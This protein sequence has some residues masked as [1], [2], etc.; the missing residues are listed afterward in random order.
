M[1]FATVLADELAGALGPAESNIHTAVP[2]FHL[3]GLADVVEFRRSPLGGAL[4]VTAGLAAVSQLELA[5]ATRTPTLWGPR[6][7]AEV[8]AGLRMRRVVANGTLPLGE[9]AVHALMFAHLPGVY[10]RTIGGTYTKV[11]LAVAITS[12]ELAACRSHGTPHVVE[13]L[14]AAGVFPFSERDRPTAATLA[15]LP[16]SA[17]ERAKLSPAG[18]EALSA[19]VHG[20]SQRVENLR[21]TFPASDVPALAAAYDSLGA[22]SQ[23]CDLVMLVCDLDDPALAPVWAK[24]IADA[25]TRTPEEREDGQFALE[26]AQARAR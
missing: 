12:D 20:Q 1:S 17:L 23:R 4:Y 16:P 3:G 8:A 26:A 13:L 11:L 15:N 18:R 22:W 5:L 19:V 6:L 25:R 10:P 24:L 2:P 21:G 7:I 14:R 9:A